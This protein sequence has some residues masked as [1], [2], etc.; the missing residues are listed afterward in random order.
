MKTFNESKR[1]DLNMLE[2]M[3]ANGWTPQF[4]YE[5]EWNKRTTPENPPVFSVNFIKGDVH[6]WIIGREKG[7]TWRVADL[8]DSHYGNHRWYSSLKEII[9]KE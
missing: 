9:K 2:E 6:A 8:I 3:K 7:R 1:E 4:A 5:D